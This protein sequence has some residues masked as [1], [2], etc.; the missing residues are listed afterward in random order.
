MPIWRYLRRIHAAEP[1]VLA[2]PSS[3]NIATDSTALR[4]VKAS[5]PDHWN[6]GKSR[7]QGSRP[8]RSAGSPGSPHGCDLNSGLFMTVSLPRRA[9]G[10]PQALGRGLSQYRE[11]LSRVEGEWGL[12]L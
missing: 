10:N 6:S 8:L 2:A 7:F 4:S 3:P 11:I 12:R 1:V 9:Q 5:E